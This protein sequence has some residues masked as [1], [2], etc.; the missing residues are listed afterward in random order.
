MKPEKGIFFLHISF[1]IEFIE[2][3]LANEKTNTTKL[4]KSLVFSK[5]IGNSCS[6]IST[7]L[8]SCNKT[9]EEINKSHGLIIKNSG[10]FFQLIEEKFIKE[11]F[12]DKDLSSIKVLN[13]NRITTL[14]SFFITSTSEKERISK[15]AENNGYTFKV[16]SP[17]DFELSI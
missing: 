12:E 3:E 10:A 9:F 11:D 8:I 5:A 6:L 7:N 4:F 14:S 1:L 16:L 13:D 17:E 15:L 2:Q